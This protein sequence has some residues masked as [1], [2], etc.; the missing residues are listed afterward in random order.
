MSGAGESSRRGEGELVANEPSAQLEEAEV[1]VDLSFMAEDSAA[2][3]DVQL[4]PGGEG[5]AP[6]GA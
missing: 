3:L 1:A 5:G 2:E 6:G 4:Q